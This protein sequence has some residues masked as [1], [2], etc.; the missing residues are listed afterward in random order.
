MEKIRTQPARGQLP[1]DGGETDG[2]NRASLSSLVS[3]FSYFTQYYFNT[4]QACK[5][6]A[7]LH[8][9]AHMHIHSHVHTVHPHIHSLYL[10]IPMHSLSYMKNTVTYIH[11]HSHTHTLIHTPHALSITHSLKHAYT[12]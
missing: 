8:T 1:G 9:C 12:N 7:S 11:T 4:Y 3:V 6:L 10:L 5:V 2:E